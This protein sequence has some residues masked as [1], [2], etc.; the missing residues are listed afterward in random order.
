MSHSGSGTSPLLN[1]AHLISIFPPARRNV[2]SV[3]V[4]HTQAV[5]R[6]QCLGKEPAGTVSRLVYLQSDEP[7]WT[8]EGSGPERERLG[9]C[10][11]AAP[12]WKR[13]LRGQ[14]LETPWNVLDYTND[15]VPSHH[16]A[17]EELRAEAH[18]TVTPPSFSSVCCF[19]A[20]NKKQN[21]KSSV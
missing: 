8:W 6:Y 9:A 15:G 17:S 12:R 18:N 14:G 7:V 13:R 10:K 11:A 19:R 20:S 2:V 5:G 16:Q 1:K 21:I 3:R 4:I